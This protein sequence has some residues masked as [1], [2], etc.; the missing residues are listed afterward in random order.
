M[1]SGVG[2]AFPPLA[3]AVAVSVELGGGMLLIFRYHVRPVPLA[4]AVFSLAPTISFHSNFA[5]S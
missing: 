2:L 1:I 3:F 5:R 4:L